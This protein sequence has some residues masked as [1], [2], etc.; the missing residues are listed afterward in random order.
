M[1]DEKACNVCG[2]KRIYNEYHRL[3]DNCGNCSVR[4]QLKYCYNYKKIF[5]K[6]NSI[7]EIL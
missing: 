7:I 3:Q 5:A 2:D 1:S 4:R 6:Q